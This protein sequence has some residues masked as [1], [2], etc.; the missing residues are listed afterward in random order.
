MAH[1][2]ERSRQRGYTLVELLVVVIMVGVLATLGVIGVRKY[3]FAAKTSEAI[4]M[5]GSI[6]AAQEAYK[7]ETF[8]YLDVS[9]GKLD[10]F[11]PMQGEPPGKKK[12]HWVNDSHV[13]WD[14]WRALGLSTANPVQFGYACVAGGASDAIPQPGTDK[15][16][17]WPA[18]GGPWYVVLA[19]AD[20]NENGVRSHYVSSSFTTEIY[21]ENEGE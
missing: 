17:D 13:D 3:V 12:Y 14:R 8:S 7:D 4:N 16:F 21:A 1:D 9:Q 20:Q 10:S 19:V 6:K 11:Y 18:P 2:G 5:I 15:S